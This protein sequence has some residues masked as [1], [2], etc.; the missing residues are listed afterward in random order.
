MQGFDVRSLCICL[1]LILTLT[2]EGAWGEE[3]YLLPLVTLEQ[4]QTAALQ[5]DY[6]YSNLD[7][8]CNKIGHA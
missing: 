1:V 7:Y 3:G 2:S 8:L 6:G 5:S 4:I